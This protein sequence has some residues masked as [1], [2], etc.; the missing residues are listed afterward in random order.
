MKYLRPAQVPDNA[1]PTPPNDQ[2]EVNT[3]QPALAP[4]LHVPGTAFTGEDA[5]ALLATAEDIHNV[6]PSQRAES[7]HAW[8]ELVSL[9]PRLVFVPLNVHIESSSLGT[10][11]AEFLGGQHSPGLSQ[12]ACQRRQ[13]G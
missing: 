3:T 10:R 1:P 4:A 7:W 6:H 11:V 13:E 5:K 12:E 8:A 2:A 9:C